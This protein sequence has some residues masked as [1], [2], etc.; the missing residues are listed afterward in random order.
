M[1]AN[2]GTV[3]GM[4][5]SLVVPTQPRPRSEA[6]GW[7]L[8]FGVLTSLALALLALAL[9]VMNAMAYGVALVFGPDLPA[10]PENS[11]YLL[12]LVFGVVVSMAGAPAVA[13]LGFGP[14]SRTWPPMALGLAAA[15]AAAVVALCALLVTLGNSPVDFVSAL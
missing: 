5:S 13:W 4:S 9:L 6:V 8:V 15:T 3:V 14:S 12:A 2:S 10:S 11:R 1:T 7:A